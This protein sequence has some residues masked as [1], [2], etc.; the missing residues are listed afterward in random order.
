MGR[1]TLTVLVSRYSLGPGP[2]GLSWVLRTYENYWCGPHHNSRKNSSDGKGP[3]QKWKYPRPKALEAQQV[4]ELCCHRCDLRWH[5]GGC[6]LLDRRV[7]GR[8]G[9]DR[10]GNHGLKPDVCNAQHH[11][12]TGAISLT[13]CHTRLLCC[14]KRADRGIRETEDPRSGWPI[15][16][17]LYTE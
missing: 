5:G 11:T 8:R 14:G 10:P 1:I 6:H 13:R 2:L 9:G 12:A 15:R 7:P 17:Y 3:L 4:L 16:H